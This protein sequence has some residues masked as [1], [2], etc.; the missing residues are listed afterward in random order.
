MKGDVQVEETKRI[1]LGN[2]LPLGVKSPFLGMRERMSVVVSETIQLIYLKIHLRKD[3]ECC[4]RGAKIVIYFCRKKNS[5]ICVALLKAALSTLHVLYFSRRSFH[6]VS[7][8]NDTHKATF[9][10]F[11]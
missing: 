6:K 11:L 2:T 10:S 4:N 9:M 1:C 7:E 8:I 5:L 3:L